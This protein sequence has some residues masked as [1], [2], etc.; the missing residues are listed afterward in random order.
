MAK[1]SKRYKVLSKPSKKHTILGGVK[2]SS[3]Q[4]SKW[5]STGGRPKKYNSNAERQRAY[6]LR[7]KQA[8]F[9]AGVQLDE[10]KTYYETKK[11]RLFGKCANCGLVDDQYSYGWKHY[12]WT[13]NSDRWVCYRCHTNSMAKQ[14]AKTIIKRAGT[15]TERSQRSRELQ[16]QRKEIASR[17]KTGCSF[18]G[19]DV[20]TQ[21]LFLLDCPKPLFDKKKK[22][23]RSHHRQVWNKFN[24][25]LSENK[26]SVGGTATW[27]YIWED[28]G[29][30]G[31]FWDLGEVEKG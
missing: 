1:P 21:Q 28:S 22:L 3:K 2:V 18:V 8:K 12:A 25:F 27:Y 29:D 5:G 16:K 30:W 17:L 15:G 10:R 11:N 14:E 31:Y 23:C 9:G 24:K 7:K 20:K 4:L 19:T 6:K 26:P 13:A